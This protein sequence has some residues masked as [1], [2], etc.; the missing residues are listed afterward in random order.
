[1]DAMYRELDAVGIVEGE[2]IRIQE[3]A[4]YVEEQIALLPK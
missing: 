3:F 1:M 4:R 2:V